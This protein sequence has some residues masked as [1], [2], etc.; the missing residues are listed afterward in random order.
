MEEKTT[1]NE[2]IKSIEPK[3]LILPV[4]ILILFIGTIIGIINYQQKAKQEKAPKIEISKPQQN[5]ILDD[6]QIVVEGKTSPGAKV[7][8]DSKEAT[9]DSKGQFALE[10]PLK[11][12]ENNLN[13]TAVSKDGKKS[14]S[15]LK[16]VR[17]T[18][19]P[20]QPAPS[21]SQPQAVAQPQPVAEVADS[22]LSSS[23][24]ENFWIPE[25]MS[26]SAIGAAWAMSRKKFSE[27]IKKRSN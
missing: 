16:V 20:A 3:K 22:N 12:G 10:A 18:K 26:L 8:V 2:K 19:Q 11:E 14:T 27:A 25:A 17:A 24:P 9:A 15:T 7:S 13:I 5:A 6:A 23:G 1:L 4:I 21:T